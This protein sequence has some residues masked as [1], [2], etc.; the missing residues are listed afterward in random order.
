MT[1]SEPFTIMDS[2]IPDGYS[3]VS[4]RSGTQKS[5]S[6][7]DRFEAR[8]ARRDFTNIGNVRDE[9]AACDGECLLNHDCFV[10]IKHCMLL[11]YQMKI[12]LKFRS[13]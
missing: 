8:S 10:Y 2:E 5:L 9:T 3:M 12:D 4:N 1:P 11:Q 13:Y 7:L 6:Y